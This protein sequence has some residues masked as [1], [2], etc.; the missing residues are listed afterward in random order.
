MRTQAGGLFGFNEKTCEEV[1]NNRNKDSLLVNLNTRIYSEYTTK[2]ETHSHLEAKVTKALQM[3][4]IISKVGQTKSTAC[5]D[6]SNTLI[7]TYN[8]NQATDQKKFATTFTYNGFIDDY[9]KLANEVLRD[10]AKPSSQQESGIFTSKTCEQVY[11]NRRL[12]DDLEGLNNKVVDLSN[13]YKIKFGVGNDKA[14]KAIEMYHI[15][16]TVGTNEKFRNQTNCKEHTYSLGG[17]KFKK[18]VLLF[19]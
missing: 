14:R 5:K 12:T 4:S 1:F 16:K 18:L 11:N 8:L 6:L 10:L 17:E 3:F 19:T 7:N 15:I 9:V 2:K 13:G